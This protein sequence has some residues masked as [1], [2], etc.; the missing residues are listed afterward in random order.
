M[1]LTILFVYGYPLVRVFDFSMR[2]IR[3]A[4]GPFIGLENFRFVLRNPVFHDAVKHN[5]FLLVGVP[6]LI[7]I[8]L[9]F[10]SLLFEQPS[11]WRFYRFSLFLP[12]ILAVPVVGVVFGY[13]LMLKGAVNEILSF[14]KLDFLA[15]DWLGNPSIALKSLLAIIIWKEMGFGIVLF[16]A[17]LMSVSEEIYDAA[18]ID[19]ANWWQILWYI[20]VPQLQIVIEFFAIVSIINL[21]SWVFAYVYVVTRGGPGTSTQVIELWIFN[22]VA[23]GAPNPGMGAAAS[24]I[25]FL[26]TIVLIF[27]LL[28]LRMRVGEEA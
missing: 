26:V 24:V 4:S 21:L 2:R 18:R 8:A 7:I 14:L 10:A 9:I 25:L 3:G 6:V 5:L 27:A 1:G 11:G 28:K 15:F 23:H 20:T 19:G 13:L 17:R 22:K 12:Y 16:F